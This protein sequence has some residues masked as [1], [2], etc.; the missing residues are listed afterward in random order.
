MPAYFR[1]IVII[2]S[3]C[4]I[5]KMVAKV[6]HTHSIAGMKEATVALLYTSNC[7]RTIWQGGVTR[8]SLKNWW[9]YF[10]HWRIKT[11]KYILF[12]L[13]VGALWVL[14]CQWLHQQVD[15]ILQL[16]DTK[17]NNDWQSTHYFWTSQFILIYWIKG[18]VI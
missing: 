5:I 1:L 3:H 11:V 2:S 9:R 15:L 6:Y 14:E 16:T 12:F 8:Q 13:G 10:N 18:I 17:H 7:D 4:N